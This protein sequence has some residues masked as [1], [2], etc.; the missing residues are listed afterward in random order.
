[1][2]QSKHVGLDFNGGDFCRGLQPSRFAVWVLP[3]CQAAW[4]AFED[5][6]LAVGPRM[7]LDLFFFGRNTDVSGDDCVFGGD[8]GD[9]WFREGLKSGGKRFFGFD[10]LN[11]CP[12][13]LFRELF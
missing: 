4:L 3:R 6:L 11:L 12:V 5:G 9:G 8:D 13:R 10:D 2:G 1:L 7:G